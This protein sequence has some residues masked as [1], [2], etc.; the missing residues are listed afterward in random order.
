VS[1]MPSSKGD[2][3]AAPTTS[4]HPKAK[5]GDSITE[6]ARQFFLRRFWPSHPKGIDVVDRVVAAKLTFGGSRAGP[7]VCIDC[8]K[9]PDRT[10][11]D[12][13]NH[14]R[15]HPTHRLAMFNVGTRCV[16]ELD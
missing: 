4:V 1:P 13:V 11:D 6:Q 9:C 7:W 15:E 3:P 16:E 5:A 14:W 10:L 8:G 12:P 2:P